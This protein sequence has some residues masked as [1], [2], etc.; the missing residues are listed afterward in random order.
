MIA[1]L[2]DS[3][4]MYVFLIFEARVGEDNDS[5]TILRTARFPDLYNLVLA[6]NKI[7]G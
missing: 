2:I 6:A 1:L 3:E 4:D 7:S 5:F